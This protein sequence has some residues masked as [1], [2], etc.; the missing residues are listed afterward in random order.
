VS[1]EIGEG[2]NVEYQ[3]ETGETNNERKKELI[4]EIVRINYHR[5]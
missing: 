4:T 5:G 2:K 3:Q 1:C